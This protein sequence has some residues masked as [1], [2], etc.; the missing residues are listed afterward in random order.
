[1]GGTG[2]GGWGHPQG[3]VCMEAARLGCKR[4][5]VGTRW[6]NPRLGCMNRLSKCYSHPLVCSFL[7]SWTQ[8]TCLPTKNAEC[9]MFVSEWAW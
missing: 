6:V 9:C 1:M 3:A 4:A 7:A 8:S 5:M 2:K